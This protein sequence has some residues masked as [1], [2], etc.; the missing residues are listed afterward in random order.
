[1]NASRAQCSEIA[2]ALGRAKKDRA[3]IP[4]L[5]D[6][7]PGLTE[8]DAYEIQFTTAASALTEGHRLVGY[9][10]GL[11]SR[12]AQKQFRVFK[13]DFGH[14]F[15]DMA[16][17]E[18]EEITLSRLIQPRIEG[19]LAFVLKDDLTGPGVTI[20]DVMSAVDF[21]TVVLE[22]VDSRIRDWKISAVDTIADNGSSA[23]FV[24]SG[25]K[26]S[27]DGIELRNVGMA[28][29]RNG[30]VTVTGA[31]AAVM[32]NP[33]SPLV[34]LANELGK[35]GRSLKAGEVILSGSFSSMLS[36]KSN[37]FFTCEMGGIGRVSVRFK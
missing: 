25:T 9:K 2:K 18:E 4:S 7:F 10:V 23:L 14:L 32:G 36:I 13:P 16:I 21:M 15:D 17:L 28:L 6:T 5:E 8:E 19:E 26:K 37:D 30:E 24:L 11:T 12:E 1:L 31:G 22:I 20:V 33:L 35:S 34:F 29:S 27:C 3:P